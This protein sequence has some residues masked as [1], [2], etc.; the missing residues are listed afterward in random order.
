MS[1]AA[2][3]DRTGPRLN[4]R[5]AGVVV[6][7]WIAEC[8]IYTL[9]Q[10]LYF[11]SAGQPVPYRDIFYLGAKGAVIWSA[12]TIAMIAMHLAPRLRDRGLPAIVGIHFAF[13]LVA[14]GFDVWVDMLFGRLTGI[15]PVTGT[16]AA[17]YFRQSTFNIF[18]Y[19][20]T[21]TVLHALELNRLSKARAI[22]AARL[23]GQL[24]QA[25][26]EVLKMQLQP[27]FLFNTLHAMAALVHDDPD[28]VER[29]ILRLGDMLRA[30]V[31]QAGRPVI[32]LADEVD[33]LQA[34]LDI[35]Q[36][37][38]RDRLTVSLEVPAATEGAAVPNLILQPLV[39][40][41]IK[42]GAARQLGPASIRVVVSRST[43][44][45]VLEVH[46]TGDPN[47][48]QPVL[49][50]GVGMRNTRARLAE[51]YPGKHAFSVVVR[52]EGGAVASIR[53]PYTDAE[54]DS[55]SSMV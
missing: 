30:A 35:E 19:F 3:T 41:A 44:E 49:V 45:L 40:N 7:L 47:G 5:T 29:M 9:Q 37:R 54:D 2:E 36:I 10:I 17:S 25:R 51:L 11:R 23:Q 15:L 22:H 50:E 12:I 13:A 4:T 42:H 27:H 46:N 53:I 48:K 14:N 55:R 43:E 28:A 21:A 8:L 33:L 6:V 52:P 34:Y 26:L 1:K 32:S 16:F 20:L 39:E 18:A 38:F 31:D 24:S